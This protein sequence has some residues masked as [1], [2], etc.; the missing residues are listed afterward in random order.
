MLVLGLTVA[1][2]SGKSTV[3]AMFADRGVATFDADRAVHALHAGPAA[4]AVEAAFPG[5]TT[6]GAVDR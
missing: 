4:A 2:A 3:T 1:L 5:T 6:N